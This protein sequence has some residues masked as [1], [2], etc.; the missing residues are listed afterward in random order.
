MELSKEYIIEG[1]AVTKGTK[2]NVL[3]ESFAGGSSASVAEKLVGILG[4]RIGTSFNFSDLPVDYSNSYGSYKGYYAQANNGLAIKVNFSLGSSDSIVSIDVYLDGID[5]TPSYTLETD[6]LNI[7]Q[8]VNLVSENLVED[9]E[10]SEAIL[11]TIEEKKNVL[12]ERG[13][14]TKEDDVVAI[15]DKWVKENRD[16]LKDLQKE[17]VPDIYNSLWSDWVADKPNYQIA[18]YLFAK[19]LKMYLLK[20]GMTNKTYRQRKKGSKERVVED[21]VLAQ[22][23]QDIVDSIS[24]K[25]KFEFVDKVLNDVVDGNI[26][27]V[28]IRGSPS[29]GK[30]QQVITTLENAGAKYK[31]YSGGVKN[32]EAL[33]KLLYVH[34]EE[35]DF[36][37]CFDDFDSILKDTDMVNIFKAI[38]QNTTNRVVTY[39]KSGEIKKQKQEER[40]E[41]FPACI[42]ISNKPK[43]DAAIE[44]RSVVL[45]IYLSND[46]MIEKINDTLEN[47]R[48]EIDMKTKKMALDFA[49]EVSKGVVAIDYRMLDNILRAMQLSPGN[50]K[51]MALWMMRSVS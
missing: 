29:S 3:Q 51:K 1:T 41:F 49:E 8:I 22:Q 44:A 23:L 5:D 25:E 50:W 17:A 33:I 40:F 43:V 36:I 46:D 10:A 28:I 42:F 38:L 39:L 34:A 2:F 45:D 9:G 13:P 35:E 21:P 48:P 7:V 30:S 12:K 26:K 24:W 18:Y 47:F 11:E 19:G 27:S 37:Y 16:I 4:R 14:V 20:N 31:L 6:D 15:I 32:V